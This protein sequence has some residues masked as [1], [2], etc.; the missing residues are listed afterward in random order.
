MKN[1]TIC[2]EKKNHEKVSFTETLIL[3]ENRVS[4]SEL[5]GRVQDPRLQIRGGDFRRFSVNI[6]ETDVYSTCLTYE[7]RKKRL[8]LDRSRAG[9]PDTEQTVS[10]VRLPKEFDFLDLRILMNRNSVIVSACGGRT[11]FAATVFTPQD[12]DGIS[13]ETDGAI[14]LDIRDSRIAV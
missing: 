8:T 5:R 12:A 14:I 13:F 11:L 7:R 4:M 3:W 2:Q 6:A 9:M 10:H 1:E